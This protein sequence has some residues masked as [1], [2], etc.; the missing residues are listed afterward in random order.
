MEEAMLACGMMNQPVPV[1]WWEWVIIALDNDPEPDKR[2]RRLGEWFSV[3]IQA[4][5]ICETMPLFVCA[6]SLKAELQT[7]D[8]GFFLR[9]AEAHRKIRFLLRAPPRLCGENLCLS[10]IKP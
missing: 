10:W 3:E 7:G 1:P 4:R 9:T 2:A 5:A 8:R 6:R